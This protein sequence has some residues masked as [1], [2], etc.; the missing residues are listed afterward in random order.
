M[1][2]MPNSAL[3]ASR[4]RRLH[5]SGNSTTQ[6][7]FERLIYLLR[8]FCGT[9]WLDGSLSARRHLFAKLK[10]PLLSRNNI[11]HLDGTVL[12]FVTHLQDSDNSCTRG[13]KGGSAKALI[14]SRRALL[15]V[16]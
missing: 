12:E 15:H 10:Q 6:I 7:Y 8:H 13:G 11:L 2:G 5:Y 16:N 14:A 4:K 1:M 9:G 3:S